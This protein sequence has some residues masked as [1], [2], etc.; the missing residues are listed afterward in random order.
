MHRQETVASRC[1]ASDAELKQFK[2]DLLAYQ[3]Q[4]EASGN[5]PAFQ[6]MIPANERGYVAIPSADQ[7]KLSQRDHRPSS[8]QGKT[9]PSCRPQTSH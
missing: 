3:A 9:M 4:Q 7:Q 2:D 5:Y 8:E 1:A 6:M